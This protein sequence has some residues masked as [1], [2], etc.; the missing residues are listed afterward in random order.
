VRRG[1][2]TR[3]D[4]TRGNKITTAH[5]GR[6]EE[7]VVQEVALALTITLLVAA[8]LNEDGKIV[9]KR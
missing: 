1:E 2:D 9:E 4:G 5:H 8:I 3:G 6:G 7:V